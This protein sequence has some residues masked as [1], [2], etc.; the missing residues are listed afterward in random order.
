M[1]LLRSPSELALLFRESNRAQKLFKKLPF[2]FSFILIV[3]VLYFA[4]L[5][6]WKVI[7]EPILTRPST[8]STRARITRGTLG[9]NS[10]T[11]AVQI[12]STSYHNSNDPSCEP[13]T[14]E[15]R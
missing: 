3:L 8:P 13:H 2:Y 11:A 4:A 1:Q 5:L 9:V 6:T 14:P 10:A 12:A 7:P 15:I